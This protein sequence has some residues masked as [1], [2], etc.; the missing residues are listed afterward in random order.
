MDNDWQYSFP[1]LE[2]TA[3]VEMVV[4][5]E[6]I[7]IEVNG[8]DAPV[9][10]SNFV[11]LVENGF[12]D[13]LMFHRVEEGFVAQGGDPQSRD[14][15][16]PPEELGAGGFIDPETG[17]ERNIPLEIKP[18]GAEE[19]IYS[20]TF[21]EAEIT[22]APELPH[23][24]GAIAMARTND[25]DTASSQFYFALDD[26]PQLDGNYA[27]FGSVTDGM[28]VV[29]EI[30][31]GDRIDYA[32]I[33]DGDIPSRSSS[34]ISDSQKLNQLLNNSNKAKVSF[35]AALFDDEEEDSQETEDELLPE[36][37]SEET[38][39]DSGEELLAEDDETVED[40][41]EEVEEET[42]EDSGEELLAEDDETVEDSLEELEDETDEELLAEDQSDEIVEEES[43]L[44]IPE[45]SELQRESSQ[46]SPTEKEEPEDS[47]TASATEE[48]EP[49]DSDTASAT[50]EEEPEDSENI[51]D[52][53][54]NTI[55]MRLMESSSGAMMGLEGEDEIFGTDEDDIINGNQGNDTIFGLEG[56][57]WLRGGKGNDSLIGGKGDDYLV[58]ELGSDTLTG[59][60]GN[61]TFILRADTASGV[62]DI[63]DADLI[64]DWQEGEGIAIVG[65]FDPA[66]DFSFELVGEDT[67]IKLGASDD[68]LGV[69]QNTAI[70]SVEENIFVVAPN[71]VALGIG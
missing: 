27:V 53:T 29:D 5:G 35:V 58:G 25:P 16:V 19:P 28:E 41:L 54:D 43:T 37:E 23:T 64:L 65:E 49:E 38:V 63:A 3:T 34:L 42:V 47:D 61:D 20:Q 18:A 59:G 7:S 50:E 68:I 9:T 45:E 52:D 46:E 36:E 44:P 48:E 2:G 1:E 32:V 17:E 21:E 11:D 15:E 33:V 22:V 60:E 57:D 26:L 6:I 71:D 55:D 40:S 30:E 56:D 66:E 70:A 67:V 69:V 24:E 8:D 62:Q 31:I 13:G 4:D 39:E 14:P 10:A 12:Y 51:A